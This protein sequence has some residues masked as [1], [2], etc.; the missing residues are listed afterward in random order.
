MTVN[1]ELLLIST[2]NIVADV[3]KYFMDLLVNDKNLSAGIDES[4]NVLTHR[5]RQFDRSIH[6]TY[7]GHK[8]FASLGGANPL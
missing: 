2:K 5:T 6:F 8:D 3:E 7:S 1:W 4:D